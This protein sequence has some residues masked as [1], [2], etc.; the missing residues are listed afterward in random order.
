MEEAIAEF[1]SL[2]LRVMITE[3]DISV[4]PTKHQGA[5]ISATELLT[6]ATNPFT[7]GLPEEVAQEHTAYYRRIFDIF[8]RHQQDIGRVTPW[9]VLDG[10][11]W[12][13]GFPVRGRTE[14]PLLFDR[15]GRSKPAFFAVQ[16]AA[17]AD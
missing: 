3:L 14:Y 13:N 10:R 17:R 5:D 11:S 8:G 2:G 6:P 15:Q 4:L 1:A 9:G 7:S 16:K 12:L